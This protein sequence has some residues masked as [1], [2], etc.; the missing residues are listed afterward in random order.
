MNEK[1][2]FLSYNFVAFN[3]R[4]VVSAEQNQQTEQNEEAENK[5]P[6]LEELVLECVL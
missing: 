3:E 6:G 1:R 2:Y 4:F 5:I